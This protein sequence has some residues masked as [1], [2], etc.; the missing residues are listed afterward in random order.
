MPLPF[1]PAVIAAAKFVFTS[2]TFVASAIRFVGA[3]LLSAALSGG[4]GP[5]VSDLKV[6]GSSYGVPLPRLYGDAVRVSGNVVDKSDLKERSKKKGKVLGLGGVRVYKYSVDLIVALCEGPQ[7]ATAVKRIWANGKLIFDRDAAGAVGSPTTIGTTGLRWTKA[8][9]THSFFENLNVYPGDALQTVD[10]VTLALH[11][12]TDL[13]YRHTAYVSISNLQLEQFGNSVPN[14]EFEFEP[15]IRVLGGVLQDIASYA[16]VGL[17]TS[18]LITTRQVRG[19][20]AASDGSVWS[21]IEP[22][23]GAFAFDVVAYANRFAAVPRG[24]YLRTVIP[25]DKL[26]TR[27]ADGSAIKR[28]ALER[29]TPNDVPDTVTITYLDATRDYQTNTQQAQRGEGFGRSKAA[30]EVPL[31]L[32]ADEAVNIANRTLYESVAAANSNT[33]YV[34]QEYRWLEGGDVIG[35]TIA[36]QIE[37]FR[38]VSVTSSPN[39]PVEL[40]G[41]F[42]DALAYSGDLTG[43]VGDFTPGALAIV[44]DTEFQPIDSSIVSD[45]DDDTGFYVAYANVEAGWVGVDLS[46]ALGTG[47]PLSYVFV[48]ESSIN[49]LIGDCTTTLPNGLVGGWDDVSTLTV[50]LVGP[51]TLSSTTKEDVETNNTNL[52]W[53]GGEDGQEGEWINF[54]TATFVSGTTWT[55]SNLLRGRYGTEFATGAHAA[56]ERFVLTDVD[57]PNRVDFGPADWN[58]AR[59]YKPVSIDDD[60]ATTDEY[61]FTNTGEGKRPLSVVQVTGTR[62]SSNNDILISWQRRSRL[63]SP[64]LGGGPV[65]LGED[66]EAYEIE[67]MNGATVVRT[68]TSSTNSVNYTTADQ[69]ADGFTPGAFRQVR[70][71]QLSDVRGRGRTNTVTV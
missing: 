33:F 36:D 15:Q 53:V 64:T 38:L 46:R 48:E 45:A 70:V 17:Y 24:R 21:A 31:V 22:L 32:T 39:G 4:K 13:A 52:A 41:V 58:V 59:T 25:T 12:G 1:V 66:V 30:I 47:S 62:N 8:N 63:Q 7:S 57:G 43:V 44:G 56:G 61:V 54:A 51:G 5:R 42:E 14:I 9:K 49:V 69:T 11:P 18:P 35:L 40:R 20:I 60:E 67:I 27:D 68:L 29:E 3:T 37:T 6:Q 55:L 16:G 28:N 19:F 26:A 23:A 2:Q 65:P 10:P 71:Y 50:T 34:P